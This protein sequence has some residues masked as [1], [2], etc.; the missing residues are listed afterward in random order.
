MEEVD[1]A[2]ARRSN[3]RGGQVLS[4]EAVVD[5]VDPAGEAR[6]ARRIERLRRL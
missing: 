6:V 4:I 5:D 1:P 3:R 2:V